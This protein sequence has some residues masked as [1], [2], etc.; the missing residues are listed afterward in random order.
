[1]NSFMWTCFLLMLL[2]YA[3]SV[4]MVM[5]TVESLEQTIGEQSVSRDEL[6]LYWGSVGSAALSCYWCITGGQ[7]WAVVI[8]PLVEQTGTQVHNVVFAMFVAF[9]TM[10]L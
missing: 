6:M 7:D 4:Y 9:A 5:M 1:M 2:V 3:L 10:V 8:G